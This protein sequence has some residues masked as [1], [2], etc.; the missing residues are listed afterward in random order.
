MAAAAAVHLVVSCA[1]AAVHLVVSCCQYSVFV[2]YVE[3]YNERIYDLL[4]DPPTK[5]GE[6]AKPRVCVGGGV[7]G[8]LSFSL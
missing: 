4:E 6:E 8:A 7:C 5:K 1:A 3:V 2:T